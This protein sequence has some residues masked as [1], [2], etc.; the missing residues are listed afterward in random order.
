MNKVKRFLDGK[1]MSWFI[2]G[3]ASFCILGG[4]FIV[5]TCYG[6]IAIPNNFGCMDYTISVF[7]IGY[8]LCALMVGVKDLIKKGK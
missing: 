3:M 4:S 8:A 6:I 2:V 5:L 7:A 1:A